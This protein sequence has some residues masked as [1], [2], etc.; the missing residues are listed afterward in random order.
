MATEAEVREGAGLR[1]KVHAELSITVLLVMT[2]M[3]GSDT[4]V[5]EKAMD[6]PI[7]AGIF[8]VVAFLSSSGIS[9]SLF[10]SSET[11]KV[12]FY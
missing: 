7:L 8:S 9:P 11:R 10:P 6:C 2:D 12:F 5:L 3:E 1:F 4:S